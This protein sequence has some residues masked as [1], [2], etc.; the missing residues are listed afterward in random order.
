MRELD[1]ALRNPKVRYEYSAHSSNTSLR[2][3]IELHHLLLYT[4]LAEKYGW[5]IQ[6][7]G[8]LNSV[9]ATRLTVSRLWQPRLFPFSAGPVQ[10]RSQT[11]RGLG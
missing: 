1:P 3:H 5:K 9:A 8:I 6:L 10:S 2:P 11:N 4:Q 7:P